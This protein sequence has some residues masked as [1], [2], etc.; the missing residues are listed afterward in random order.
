MTTSLDL[1]RRFEK[2]H[3]DV[4]RAIYG[5]LAEAP[6]EFAERNFA[7]SDFVDSTGRRLS[8]YRLSRDAFALLAMGF[9]GKEAL[10]W[11]IRYLEAFNALEAR[12]LAQGQLPAQPAMES[13]PESA[14]ADQAFFA[15]LFYAMG[16]DMGMATTLYLLL[17]HGAHKQWVALS[18][19]EMAALVGK[20][21]SRAT[22]HQASARLLKEEL[23]LLRRQRARR[24]RYYVP[25]QPLA[26][27]LRALPG[28]PG[29]RPG[30]PPQ[31]G[32]L[33]ANLTVH[34]LTLL[35]LNDN[36]EGEKA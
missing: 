21:V 25:E 34:N 33:L 16:K 9:T 5:I 10:T 24:T 12:V 11:K 20:V 7:L 15:R 6:D 23:I 30:L 17:L 22:F 19:R 14:S 2:N 18:V 28:E 27:R 29:L 4:L 3:K 1:A 26:A 13:L 32:S 31:F 8:L 36:T 35:P